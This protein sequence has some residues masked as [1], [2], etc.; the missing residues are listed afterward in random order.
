MIIQF[1]ILVF[2]AVV[3]VLTTRFVLINGIESL[4]DTLNFS[5]KT[6]GKIIGYATSL[7]EFSIVIVSAFVGVFEA[8]IWNIV[9]SNI[10]NLVLFVSA[11]LYYRQGKDL[12]QKQ[13]I[14]EISFVVLSLFIPFL[15]LQNEQDISVKMSLAL[16]AFFAFY[17]IVDKR[18]NKR[19]EEAFNEEKKKKSSVFKGFVQIVVGVVLITVASNYIGDSAGILIRKLGVPSYLIGWILGFLSSLPEMTSFFEIYRL[20]KVKIKGK[21]LTDGTQ[22][23]LDTLVASNMSNLS[24]ILPIGTLVYIYLSGN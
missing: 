21:I 23:A 1:L 12:F 11:L 16:F 19:T 14:D 10:I 24:I 17:I 4:C 22:K 8:G 9:S 13:F 18:V 2:F 7:P 15:L 3:I 5:I 6:K 20:E